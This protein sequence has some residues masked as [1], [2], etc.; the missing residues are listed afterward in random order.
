MDC[1][2][3]EAFKEENTLYVPM[4]VDLFTT[5]QTFNLSVFPYDWQSTIPLATTDLAE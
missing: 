3:L 1:T 2:L 5:P 4:W